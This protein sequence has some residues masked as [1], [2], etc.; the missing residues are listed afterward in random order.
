MPAYRRVLVTH[1]VAATVEH[2]GQPFAESYGTVIDV[3]ANRGQ[4]AVFARRMWP[5]ARLLCFEPL[6][7]ARRVLSVVANQL[8]NVRVFP[9]ALSDESGEQRMRVAQADDSSSLLT[10]TRRQ[11]D[12]FPKTVKVG[13]VPV[14]AKRLD[15]LT[16]TLEL[17]HPVLLKI[18]VQGAELQVLRGAS[19][20]LHDADDALIE[21]SLVELYEEQSLI[22]ETIEFCRNQG[23][24]IRGLSQPS[25]GPDGT[26][27]QCDVL[28]RR[29]RE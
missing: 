5:D 27:L 2:E 25:R 4:F 21:C 15:E 26:P 28:F 11:V 10:A 9:Y 20:M 1:R 16:E 12:A 18:D 29:K 17:P 8:G 7:D 14:D 13:E 19:E 6:P 23:F 3:G 24:R 22:D